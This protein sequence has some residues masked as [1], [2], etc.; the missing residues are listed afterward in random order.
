MDFVAR[1]ALKVSDLAA[2]YEGHP[3]VIHQWQKAQSEGAAG[4]FGRGGTPA[5]VVYRRA[6]EETQDD[7]P[8]QKVA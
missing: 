8:V 4:T 3:T 5:S 1:E 7:G 6:I 2:S